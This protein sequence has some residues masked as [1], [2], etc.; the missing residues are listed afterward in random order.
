MNE[1]YDERKERL[2]AE[3]EKEDQ[4]KRQASQLLA[5]SRQ[6]NLDEAVERLRREQTLPPKSQYDTPKKT[7][8]GRNSST[9]G[10]QAPES[11]R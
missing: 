8:E 10:R 11:E 4:L 2:L 1:K 3:I 5:A 7:E 6:K 9:E